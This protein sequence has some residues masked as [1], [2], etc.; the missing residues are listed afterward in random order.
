M[1]C[2]QLSLKAVHIELSFLL[3]DAVFTSP[4]RPQEINS[5]HSMLMH[6]HIVPA[7]IPY[8]YT[9]YLAD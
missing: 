6:T 3:K 4:S 5:S 1:F 8:V 7:I 2:V 9:P